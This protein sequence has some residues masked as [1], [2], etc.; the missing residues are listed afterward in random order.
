[1]LGLDAARG[2]AILAMVIAH[3]IPFF[4]NVPRPVAIVLTQINDVASPLFAIVMGATTA[5]AVQRGRRAGAT[6]RRSLAMHNLWRGLV[7]IALGLGL[8]QL[9]TWVAIILHILGVLL[10]VGTPL[11]FL[12]PRVQVL[13][14]I[15]LTLVSPLIVSSLQLAAHRRPGVLSPTAPSG[16]GTNRL[17]EWLVLNPHYRVLTLLP[18]FLLGAALQHWGASSRASVRTLVVGLLVMVSWVVAA[19]LGA[20]PVSGDL[21]DQ[22][23][24]TGLALAAY[25]VFMA[26]DATGPGPAG[27]LRALARP[28]AAIG[29]LALSLYVVHVGLLWVLVP[30]FTGRDAESGLAAIGW[31]LALLV[32]T[33]AFGWLWWRFLGKG[34]IERL[35]DLVV[36]RRA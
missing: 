27:W 13:L 7:L 24:E 4:G 19:A 8:E 17:I 34:P 6:G 30:R 3:A 1:M 9:H 10:I 28:I 20:H 11:A 5:L 26:L 22:C 25:G 15:T 14:A 33:M 36:P 35:I 32:P 29:T 2:V 18:L 16:W 12:G 21:L 31:T 23:H